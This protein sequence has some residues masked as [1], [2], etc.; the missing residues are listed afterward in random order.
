[1]ERELWPALYQ[2]VREVGRGVHQ[3][4]VIY[5]PW[6]IAAVIL[7]AAVHDRPVS[8]ACQ[9]AHWSTTRCRPLELPAASTISRRARRLSVFWR[10]LE[11]RCRESQWRGLLSFVD[12]RPLFVGG[13]TK[14]PDARRGYGA[15]SFGWGYKLHAIWSNR[16]LPEGWDVTP[17]NASE[18]VV[19]QALVVGL[20]S[21][22]YLLADG[23]YETNP[24]AEAAGRAGYQL[25]AAPRRPN[26]GKGHRR[27]SPFRQRGLELQTQPFGQ[28]L[29]A[30]RY[31]IELT[32]AHATSFGGGLT[33][34]PPW[35]RRLHRIRTW[36]WAKLLI[37]AVRILT[38]H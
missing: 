38:K 4:N 31:R 5:Q 26:A 19:G 14:D 30:Q 3:K 29:F 35:V 37:N 15:G 6:V 9:P 1:M 2:L 20:S 10:M 36:V 16:C 23:S 34:P 27:H 32:F 8:W 24:L 28:R 11:A 25:V 13:C 33:A 17:M 12:G 18:S 21:G 7:W 22:G